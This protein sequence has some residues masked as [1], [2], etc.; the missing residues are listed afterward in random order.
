M[1]RRPPK[2]RAMRPGPF[3]PVPV[4]RGGRRPADPE[5]RRNRVLPVA[6]S[7]AEINAVKAAAQREG[8]STSEWARNALMLRAAAH[9][10]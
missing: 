4:D 7:D 6:L 5:N 8:K 1:T 9:G 3:G 10:E 2:P